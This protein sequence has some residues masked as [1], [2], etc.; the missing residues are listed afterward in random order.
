ME[1]LPFLPPH[2]NELRLLVVRMSLYWPKQRWS[3]LWCEE[4]QDITMVFFTLSWLLSFLLLFQFFSDVAGKISQNGLQPGLLPASY[5]PFLH[6]KWRVK[7]TNFH[8][9]IR[10][11]VLI[12]RSRN[13][14]QWDWV[15]WVKREKKDVIEKN[16][17]LYC[18]F[19]VDW[20]LSVELYNPVSGW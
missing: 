8:A 12:F 10:N 16:I 18:S 1:S 11:T 6:L 17:A 4:N 9:I 7:L 3:G 15:S 2:P 20:Q 5:W 14:V 19:L 13:K